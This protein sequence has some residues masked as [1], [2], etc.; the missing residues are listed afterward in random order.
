MERGGNCRDCVQKN[1]RSDD[2]LLSLQEKVGGGDCLFVGEL[3]LR[4][5]HEGGGKGWAAC[6]RG[7]HA[8]NQRSREEIQ[9]TE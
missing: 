3:M 2:H 4:K 1:E 6:V 9:G 7:S 5:N 8:F